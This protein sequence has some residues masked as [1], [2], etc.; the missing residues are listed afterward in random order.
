[1]KD[2]NRRPNTNNRNSRPNQRSPRTP[3]NIL[4]PAAVLEDYEDAAPGS[5]NKLMD[6]AE[7][8]Q[9]HRHFWQDK[10]LKFHGFSYKIGLLCGFIYNFG[11]LFLVYTLVNEGRESLALKLFVINALLIAFAIVVTKI[12]RRVTTRKPPRR[13]APHL[14]KNRPQSKPASK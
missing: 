12:E 9:T 2:N 3:Y 5:V 8:E 11:L 4:P 10:F 13:N 7:K 1:M 6:M 14:N